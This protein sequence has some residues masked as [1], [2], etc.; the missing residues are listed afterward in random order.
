[1]SEATHGDRFAFGIIGV[2]V[3]A[4]LGLLIWWLGLVT[5][6]IIP[7]GIAVIALGVYGVGWMITA[8]TNFV[9]SK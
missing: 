2:V 8:V 3:L 1:M 9:D 4:V 7:V 5:V 6:L